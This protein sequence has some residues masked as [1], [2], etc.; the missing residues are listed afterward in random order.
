MSF[1]Y[2][3]HVASNT[4]RQVVGRLAAAGV[5]GYYP[6]LLAKSRDQRREVERRFFPGY[7]FARFDLANRTPVLQTPH[8]IR[9]LG[10]THDQPAIIPDTEIQAVRLMTQAAVAVAAHPF[11]PA[12]TRVVIARGPLQGLAG[13]VVESKKGLRVV[14]SVMMLARSIAA[15]VDLTDLDVT[16]RAA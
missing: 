1:W 10:W 4:E 16:G 3:L 9:I 13:F 11:L 7:V 15:E 6:H 14:V 5:E 8:V 2:A 12:G